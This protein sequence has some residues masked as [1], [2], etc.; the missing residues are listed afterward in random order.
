M[1]HL[2]WLLGNVY[3][4]KLLFMLTT[5]VYSIVTFT[6]SIACNGSNTINGGLTEP[7]QIQYR[8]SRD[9]DNWIT[10]NGSKNQITLNICIII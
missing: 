6:F 8:S 9:W 1:C 4:I 5:A 2:K 10:T 3:M 7:V